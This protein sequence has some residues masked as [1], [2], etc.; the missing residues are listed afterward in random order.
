MNHEIAR[1]NYDRLSRWYDLFSSS[2]RRFTEIGYKLLNVCPGEKV[3]E[4]RIYEWFH[5]RLPDVVDC[6]PILVR[7][8]LEAAGFEVR[9]AAEKSIWR[10]PAQAVL[11][12][13]E[14]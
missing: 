10:L 14:E 1:R 3:L 13:K 8:L 2:E 11:A 6:R 5:A 4:I 9:E 12:I 7:P